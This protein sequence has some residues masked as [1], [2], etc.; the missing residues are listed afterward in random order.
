MNAREARA[1]ERLSCEVLRD[2]VLRRPASVVRVLHRQPEDSDDDVSWAGLPAAV[3]HTVRAEAYLRLQRPDAAF[4]EVRVAIAA[5]AGA[6]D[7]ITADAPPQV[8]PLA[9]VY[10]DLS[11]C[12]GDQDAAAC[13]RVY[14]GLAERVGEER[15]TQ[16][17][18][19]L[20]AVAVY[21]HEDGERGRLYLAQALRSHRSV[22]GDDGT[23]RMLAE[24]L[25]VMADTL[26]DGRH[27]RGRADPFRIPVPGG[28]LCPDET[29]GRRHYLASR[30]QLHPPHLPP[31]VIG[32]AS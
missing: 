29:R 1:A 15:R 14:Q 17:A 23:S 27:H 9:A 25:A 32:E 22:Y 13:C 5:I 7:G 2:R 21:H 24:G 31:D 3:R 8:L 18:A 28:R 11:V 30:I 6:N 16:L 19:A 26:T 4:A 20:H 12:V 10:A